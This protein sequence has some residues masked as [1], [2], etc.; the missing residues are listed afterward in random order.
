MAPCG[1]QQEMVATYKNNKIEKV[2]K[3]EDGLPDNR[4]ISLA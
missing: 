3:T 4:I 2:I 1:L